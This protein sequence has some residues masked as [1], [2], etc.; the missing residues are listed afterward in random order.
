MKPCN[1]TSRSLIIARLSESNKT[2]SQIQSV[3]YLVSVCIIS[4][5]VGVAYRAYWYI[6][7]KKIKGKV[8]SWYNKIYMITCIGIWLYWQPLLNLCYELYLSSLK[9]YYFFCNKLHVAFQL[10][11]TSTECIALDRGRQRVHCRL[12]LWILILLTSRCTRYNIMW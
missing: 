5:F 3:Q 8:H 12:T 4:Q 7:H 10:K 1:I 6:N 9:I 11:I 2:T